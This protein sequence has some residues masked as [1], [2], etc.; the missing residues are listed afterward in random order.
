[1]PILSQL[2]ETVANALLLLML[3]LGLWGMF[4]GLIKRP[5][6]GGFRATYVLSIGFF[7]VQAVIGAVLWLSGSR[8]RDTLH[9]LYGI[10][11]FL[12]LGYALSY[13]SRMK[14]RNEALTLGIA[15]LFTFG[16]IIR[17]YTTGR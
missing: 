11:P 15:A 3:L 10:A 17:A 16:L 2:H 9:I 1:M 5:L 14:P 12:A 8:P 13:G 7:G 6:G 4:M